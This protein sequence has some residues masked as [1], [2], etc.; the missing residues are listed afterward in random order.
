MHVK[1]E[2]F[3]G[4]NT[5]TTANAVMQDST[6]TTEKWDGISIPSKKLFKIFPY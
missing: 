1:F 6:R 3:G 2:C 4:H 5:R